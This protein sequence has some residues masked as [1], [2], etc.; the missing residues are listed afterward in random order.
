MLARLNPAVP[1]MGSSESTSAMALLLHHTPAGHHL[2]PRH[3][4]TF[5]SHWDALIEKLLLL[6]YLYVTVLIMATA[7]TPADHP[8]L[9]HLQGIHGTMKHCLEPD[10]VALGSCLG[11]NRAFER[12]R[13]HPRNRDDAK[14]FLDD[15]RGM[16]T[17]PSTDN[18][19]SRIE[20]FLVNAYCH[21]HFEEIVNNHFVVWKAN[22]MPT[23]DSP[24]DETATVGDGDKRGHS[25]S[26][27]N[28]LVEADQGAGA[29]QRVEDVSIEPV[30]SQFTAMSV[31]TTTHTVT[32]RDLS[33]SHNEGSRISGLGICTLARK[34]SVRDGSQI[35]SEMYKYLG[36]MQQ[37]K[38]IVYVLRETT[39]DNLFKIGFS[40]TTAV[41]RLNQPRNCLKTNADVMILYESHGGPFVAAHKAEK[42]AQTVLKNHNLLISECEECGGGHREWFQASES[43]VMKAVQAMERFVQMPAYE[44]TADGIWKLS[45]DGNEVAQTMC[46][47]DLAKLEAFVAQSES[48]PIHEENEGLPAQVQRETV[49]SVTADVVQIETVVSM[50]ADPPI[51]PASPRAGDNLQGESTSVATSPLYERDA[52]QDRNRSFGTEAAVVGKKIVK[53]VK[54]M[55]GHGEEKLRRLRARSLNTSGAQS[56]G[57]QDPMFEK[58]DTNTLRDVI[59]DVF[60]SMV[61]EDVRGRQDDGKVPV[62]Q[63]GISWATKVKQDLRTQLEDY[64]KEWNREDE[65]K[66]FA[67]LSC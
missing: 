9:K 28:T 5:L 67:A 6:N 56:Q 20:K 50:S 1:R 10:A 12:C 7:Q 15:V 33:V 2:C 46:R 39:R 35:F 38:G 8:V 52:G 34:G 19:I 18:F 53:T 22:T 54:T 4:R 32:G 23:I 65:H 55:R 24:A 64:E 58:G 59:A 66:D 41:E 45:A 49:T 62:L 14:A 21:L 29:S 36:P 31:S 61:P 48:S 26:T 13:K 60:W 30:V 51:P 25:I 37:K 40:Q 47:L 42:L 44:E 27:G 3:L 16:K 57:S 63:R 11:L 17:W 43:V